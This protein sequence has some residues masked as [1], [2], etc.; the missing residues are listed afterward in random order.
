MQT[1]F[2][3]PQN[4][5]FESHSF[6]LFPPEFHLLLCDFLLSATFNFPFHYLSISALSV[7]LLPSFSPVQTFGHAAPPNLPYLL[8]L[9]FSS[10]RGRLCFFFSEADAAS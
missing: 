6:Q 3:G 4:E 1:W 5:L 7:F 2:K 8:K 10:T 9:T